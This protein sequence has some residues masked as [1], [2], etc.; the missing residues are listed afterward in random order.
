MTKPFNVSLKSLKSG[1]FQ[2][3]SLALT[4]EEKNKLP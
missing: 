2:K 1:I 3:L 4:I